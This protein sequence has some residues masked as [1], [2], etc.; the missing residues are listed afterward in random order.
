MIC[1]FKCKETKL[2]FSGK[3]SRKLPADIQQRAFIKLAQL[4]AAVIVE[5]L[6]LPL[7]NRLEAL[8]GNRKGNWSIRINNQWRICFRFEPD[9]AHDVEITDYH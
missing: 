8:S 6:M 9:G 1:S 4:D 7:S 5:D 2:L 3:K